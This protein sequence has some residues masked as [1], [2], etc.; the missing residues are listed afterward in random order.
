[1]ATLDMNHLALRHRPPA[2]WVRAAVSRWLAGGEAWPLVFRALSADAEAPRGTSANV[3]VHLP[4]CRR[5]CPHCPYNRVLLRPGL[6]K[7]YGAA[8]E[9]ELAAYL[10]RPGVPAVETLY[11][12]GGTPSLTP[13]L[14]EQVV[15]MS[16]PSLTPQAEIGVEVHPADASPALLESLREAGVNRISL[17]IETLRP[18]LLRMLT[19]HYS[20]EAA[21][22]AVCAARRAGFGCVDVNLIHAIPG[23]SA[24]DAASDAERCV[25]L[26]VDQ[27]SAY[28]LFSFAHTPLGKRSGIRPPKQREQLAAQKAVS[29]V[30]REGGLQRS[31]VWSFTRPGLSPY[32]TVTHEDYV[33]FGAGAGSK[34]AGVFWFNTF[35]VPGYAG[36]RVARP[37]LIMQ[38]GERLR[39]AH[40]LYWAIYRTRVESARYAELFG[41]G[42]DR[43]FGVLLGVLC[44]A[45]LA[46]RDA[47]GWTLTENGAIWVH[48][49]QS[50]YSLTYIDEL[51]QRCREDGWPRQVVLA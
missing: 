46:R 39:R 23:Q 13:E 40:W 32:S 36:S 14:I 50:L 35:S 30:C 24:A 9:R 2:R 19:R 31:S 1:M 33:G 49:L 8:L 22:E 17:G 48:R 6:A 43:D 29:R 7:A 27:I 16:R 41:H 51:W 3:Y 47:A 11:F 38:A 42:I 25:A 26:G 5:I 15:T 28:P 21:L 12:G 37:A 10:Q 45:R 18:D 4:F 20:P 34:V 44:A